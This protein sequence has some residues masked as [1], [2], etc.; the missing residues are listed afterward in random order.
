MQTELEF[1]LSAREYRLKKK[2]LFQ[3]GNLESLNFIRKVPLIET[4][5]VIPT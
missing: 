3:K 2:E 5:R 1:Q 4:K